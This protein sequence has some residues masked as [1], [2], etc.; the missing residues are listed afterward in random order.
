MFRYRKYFN[1]LTWG[2]SLSSKSESTNMRGFTTLKNKYFKHYSKLCSSNFNLTSL[3]AYR[4]VPN[5]RRA[6]ITLKLCNGPFGCS[7][8]AKEALF[9]S[10]RRFSY[11]LAIN[12]KVKLYKII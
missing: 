7:K 6:N 9:K 3:K 1:E 2:I 11:G 4:R 12:S 10:F 8:A 5:W